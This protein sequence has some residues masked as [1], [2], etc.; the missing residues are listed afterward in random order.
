M[1]STVLPVTCAALE[2]PSVQPQVFKQYLMMLGDRGWAYGGEENNT[3][4]AHSL[5]EK[6]SYKM[7]TFKCFIL[8]QYKYEY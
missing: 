4:G 6:T 2:D 7:L 5:E 1:F 8:A 3:R